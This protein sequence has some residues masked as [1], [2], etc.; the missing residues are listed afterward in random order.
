MSYR[1][2]STPSTRQQVLDR[3]TE[4]ER[5]IQNVRPFDRALDPDE[6]RATLEDLLDTMAEWPRAND[7]VCAD[8]G[9]Q[10][11]EFRICRWYDRADQAPA[12][13]TTLCAR[14]YAAREDGQAERYF[15][16]KVS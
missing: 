12:V 11:P 8:C 15:A 9:T 7:A 13:Y 10:L 14:C 1:A 5:A 4:L 3:L 6:A 16:R 2:Y